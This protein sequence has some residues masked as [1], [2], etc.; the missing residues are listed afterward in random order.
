MNEDSFRHQ[1][2]SRCPGTD[3]RVVSGAAASRRTSLGQGIRRSLSRACRADPRGLSCRSP[4]W[5]WPPSALTLPV[6]A[7]P[8]IFAPECDCRAGRRASHRGMQQASP[9]LSALGDYRIIREIG[10]GG[11][12]IVYEAER[13]ALHSRVALKVMHPKFAE[14]MPIISAGSSARPAR[15]PDCT[16]PTS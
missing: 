10:G 9:L 11:M 6:P 5:N 4:K 1:L 15:R 16:T 14:P 13:E 8:V 7:P 2:F 3:R 12:G